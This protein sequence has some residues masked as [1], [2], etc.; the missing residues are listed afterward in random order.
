MKSTYTFKASPADTD[1]VRICRENHQAR[2]IVVKSEGID[3]LTFVRIYSREHY[4]L[5]KAGSRPS[6][7]TDV[8]PVH[9]PPAD[10]RSGQTWVIFEGDYSKELSPKV[11]TTVEVYG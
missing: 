9:V 5:R 2:F 1:Y 3:P 6:G 10:G 4:M 8:R 7:R 11:R